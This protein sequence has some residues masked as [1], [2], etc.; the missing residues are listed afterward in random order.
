MGRPS[1]ISAE[2]VELILEAIRKGLTYREAATLAGIN[3]ATLHRWRQRGKAARS[4]PFFE[5]GPSR[6]GLYP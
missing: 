3:E 2:I 5:F 4:G 1:K 6:W